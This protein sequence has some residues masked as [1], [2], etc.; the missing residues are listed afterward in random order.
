VSRIG[1]DLLGVQPGNEHLGAQEI[2][3]RVYALDHQLVVPGALGLAVLTQDRPTGVLIVES[4]VVAEE[5]PHAGDDVTHYGQQGISGRG[6]WRSVRSA[7]LR[8]PS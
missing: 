1:L 4:P 2:H 6:V 7:S 5:N 8:L 3:H